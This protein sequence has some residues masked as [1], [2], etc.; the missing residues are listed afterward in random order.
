MDLIYRTGQ[1]TKRRFLFW[2]SKLKLH[3]P[4]N[5]AP[6]WVSL[7]T[8]SGLR[9]TFERGLEPGYLTLLPLSARGRLGGAPA[10]P[11]LL[12]I[13]MSLLPDSVTGPPQGAGG[14]SILDGDGGRDRGR[15]LHGTAFFPL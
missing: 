6:A 14:N 2:L 9:F 4:G 10:F 13:T 3:V 5:E 12:I 1:P 11:P 7:D 8:T 15:A